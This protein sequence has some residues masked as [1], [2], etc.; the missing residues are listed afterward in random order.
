[1][2]LH[3][4]PRAARGDGHLLVVIARRAAGGEGIA[5]PEAVFRGDAVGDVGKAGRALVRGNYQIRVVAIMAQHA[6]RR[7]DLAV[8]QV[9][10]DVEHAA[11]ERLIAGNAF[12][13]QRIAVACRRLLQHEAALCPD[14][15]D[16]HVLH[17]LRLHQAEHFGAEVL[18]AV[19]PADAAARDVAAAQVHGL[20]SRRVHPDLE[21]RL[22]LGQPRHAFRIELE[23]DVR[24]VE[25]EIAAQRRPDH[26][27]EAPQDPV[28]VEVLHRIQ[29]RTDLN[30]KGRFAS[31]F[32]AAC[33]EQT[34]EERRDARV[35]RQRLLDVRQAERRPRLAQ[36]ARIGAQ[37]RDLARAQARA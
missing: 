24:L 7:H 27:E 18:H 1:M 20:H 4:L 32:P 35:R 28:L 19:G 2:A 14:R 25:K 16:D 34:H 5:E 36:V 21:E 10:G 11:Q 6:F 29:R 8:D 3:R 33:E 9:V 37:N 15:H 12:L 23:R 30:R 22:G 13:H 26:G 31:R 17:H